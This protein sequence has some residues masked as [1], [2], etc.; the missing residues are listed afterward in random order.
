MMMLHG[1]ERHNTPTHR[2]SH[3]LLLLN[4][5]VRPHARTGTLT[6]AVPHILEKREAGTRA[7]GGAGFQVDLVNSR[8]HCEVTARSEF[9]SIATNVQNL[10][11]KVVCVRSLVLLLLLAVAAELN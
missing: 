7:K 10:D 1:Q 5:F 8:S 9:E 2:K 11:H 4:A 6:R 3:F